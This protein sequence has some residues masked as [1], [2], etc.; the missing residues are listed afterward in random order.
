MRNFKIQINAIDDHRTHFNAFYFWDTDDL[1]IAYHVEVDDD[2]ITCEKKHRFIDEYEWL[3]V[4]HEMG[5]SHEECVDLV[6]SVLMTKEVGENYDN[7]LFGLL[8][9]PMLEYE[10]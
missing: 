3:C 9:C 10:D 4:V 8:G 7:I 1:K 5:F 6:L 2:K